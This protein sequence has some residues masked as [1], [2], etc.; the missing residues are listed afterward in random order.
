MH[1]GGYFFLRK[2]DLSRGKKIS[3]FL[4]IR[5]L[6]SIGTISERTY[7]SLVSSYCTKLR[8]VRFFCE[9]WKDSKSGSLNISD[10]LSYVFVDIDYRDISVI[11]DAR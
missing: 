10:A 5:A 11:T 7:M 3:Q 2:P 8:S 1:V 4:S 6:L 9:L